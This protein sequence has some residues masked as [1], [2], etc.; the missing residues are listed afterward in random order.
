MASILPVVEKVNG[1]HVQAMEEVEKVCK[2]VES[3]L[4][5]KKYGLCDVC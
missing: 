2:N 4:R 5:E 1:A 3:Y